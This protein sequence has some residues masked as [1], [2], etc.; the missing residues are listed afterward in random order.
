MNVSMT[1]TLVHAWIV[2]RF[3]RLHRE[4]PNRGDVPGWVIVT[5]ITV[6]LALA[7]GAIIV[8][9]ITGKANTINLQ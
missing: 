2:S 4:D 8:A 6:T 5:G 1:I 3:Q 9:K 7:I